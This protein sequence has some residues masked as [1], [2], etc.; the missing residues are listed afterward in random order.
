MLGKLRYMG[1]DV[2]RLHS[3]RAGE[4]TANQVRK[5]TE[6]QGIFRT[7]TDGDGWKSNGRVESEIAVLKRGIKTLL[8]S[9][10]L[11]D[12]YWPL[13]ARHFAERRWRQQLTAMNYPVPPLKVFGSKAWAKVKR[14][15]DRSNAWRKARKEVMILG[16]DATMSSSSQGYYVE[17]QG[18]KFFHSA[19]L[20]EGAEPPQD[21]EDEEIREEMFPEIEEEGRPPRR[22]RRKTESE[23]AQLRRMK[24]EEELVEGRALERGEFQRLQDLEEGWEPVYKVAKEL[25]TENMRLEQELRR[26]DS[27]Q[28]E[29]DME[30]AL[31]VAD[32]GEVFLQT[33][34]IPLSEVRRDLSKWREAIQEEYGSLTQ[35]GALRPIDAEEAERLRKMAEE[36]HLPYD[37]L[38]GKAVFTRKAPSGKY[39]CRGVACGNYMASRPASE[40][41]AGGI[42]A[43]QVRSILCS[44]VQNRWAIA[45]TDIKCAFLQVPTGRKKDVIVIQPP[46]VFHEAGVVTPQELWHVDGNIYGLTTSPRDWA[47]HRDSTFQSFTWQSDGVP[48]GLERTK[49]ENLWK[50]RKEVDGKWV[51][52]GHLAVYIDDL[53]VTGE[54]TLVEDFLE[55][56]KKEWSVSEPEWCTSDATLRFCGVEVDRL[57]DGIKIHQESYVRDLLERHGTTGTSTMSSVVTPEEEESVEA[58]D[59]RL[60]QVATGELLW[61][62]TRSRPDLSFPVAIMCQWAV[63]RPKGVLRIGEEVRKYLNGSKG[64]G[65]SY[66]P[67]RAGDHGVEGLQHKP[68]R[69]NAIEVFCDASYGSQDFKS[70][71]GFAVFYA[72]CPVFWLTC[73]QPFIAMSTAESELLAMMEGVTASRGVSSLVEELEECSCEKYLFSDSSAAIAIVNGSSGSWRTR[74]LRMR[75][76]ILTEAVRNKE[77]YLQHFPGKFLVADGLTKQLSNV[78]FR[79][80]K[81]GLNLVEE[82]LKV[83][84]VAVRRLAG[85]KC[86]KMERALGLLVT[87]CGVSEARGVRSEETEEEEGGNWVLVLLVAITLIVWKLVEK[88]AKEGWRML[89][90][91]EEVSIERLSTQ[92]RMPETMGD[93]VG[94]WGMCSIEEKVLLPGESVLV[95]TGIKVEVPWGTRG[96]LAAGPE[97]AT[98]N[99]E[100]G[101]GILQKEFREE[102]KVLLRNGGGKKV[103]V[104]KGSVI[105][106]LHVEKEVQTSLKEKSSSSSFITEVPSINRLRVSDETP[107]SSSATKRGSSSTAKRVLSGEWKWIGHGSESMRSLIRRKHEEFPEWIQ[108][109]PYLEALCEKPSG[110]VGDLWRCLEGSEG[111]IVVR[112]HNQSRIKFYVSLDGDIA[113]RPTMSFAWYETGQCEVV[114][115]QRPTATNFKGRWKC[116]TVCQWG[117]GLQNA[118][119]ALGER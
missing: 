19:D 106:R 66:Q 51:T 115:S 29:E 104:E 72:G 94:G 75:S 98:Q 43:T 69:R 68:R 101:T 114:Y 67:L 18:G 5:W 84:E 56:V 12:N 76:S 33:R 34:T 100:V 73:R 21:D 99:V 11:A 15:E 64:M 110:H 58:S 14:W 13:A 46:A 40:T 47:N 81:D 97:M 53:L 77:L 52:A 6:D 93:S 87:L 48:C 85:G 71:S 118:E 103:I 70:T 24:V 41:Y 4:F 7:F 39:K 26:M 10:G 45:G 116:F 49:E 79:R 96:R 35:T 90:K 36:N 17:D 59:V 28:R 20:V 107:S 9:A 32:Q 60:A 63:K 55:R 65:L 88:V 80:F 102:V 44:A 1:L 31:E 86:E 3:D 23:S 117:L 92:A 22:L 54:Q 50:L 62:A 61:L 82:S 2:R 112:E 111:K 27:L 83:E 57:G 109:N 74:H 91:K 42:D 78:L 119:T 16:P 89:T 108:E 38:P 95:R 113:N 25:V 8:N 105:A 30:E 37:R